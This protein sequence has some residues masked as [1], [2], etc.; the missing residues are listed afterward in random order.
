LHDFG[1]IFRS[2]AADSEEVCSGI[3]GLQRFEDYFG[4]GIGDC[5]KVR[6]DWLVAVVGR[7]GRTASD[8][9]YRFAPFPTTEVDVDVVLIGPLEG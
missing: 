3:V 1:Q 9:V 5:R 4:A 2:L 8:R 6:N 7:T